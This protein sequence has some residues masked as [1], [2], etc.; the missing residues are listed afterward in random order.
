MATDTFVE[1]APAR[2]P[3]PPPPARL[4]LR[5]CPVGRSY[6]RPTFLLVPHTV[7]LLLLPTSVSFIDIAHT[8]YCIEQVA[9]SDRKSAK[10]TN[11][12]RLMEAHC[13]KL[14]GPLYEDPIASFS[15]FQKYSVDH[16][17][18]ALPITSSILQYMDYDSASLNFKL[19][20]ASLNFKLFYGAFRTTGNYLSL[21][22][23]SSFTKN[24]NVCGRARTKRSMAGHGFQALCLIL[25]KVVCCP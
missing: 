15:L 20:Y 21:S 8:P 24:R 18:V 16:P 3:P 7:S 6:Q 2:P 9:F 10:Q 11:L 1:A 17:Q 4:L 25:Q 19:F 5:L 22:L 23:L 13:P 14:L 12:G